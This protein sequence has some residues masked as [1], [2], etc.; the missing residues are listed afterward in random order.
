MAIAGV[1]TATLGSYSD[2]TARRSDLVALRERIELIDQDLP[3]PNCANVV[4]R[5]KSGQRLENFADVSEPCPDTETQRSKLTEKFHRLVVPVIG[6]ERTGWLVSAIDQM[7]QSPA[8]VAL[9]GV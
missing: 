9:F 6:D 8:A 3:N 5:T 4:I 2:E 1:D 7:D